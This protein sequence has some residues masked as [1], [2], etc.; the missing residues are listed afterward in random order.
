MEDV[1]D[2]IISGIQSDIER[3]EVV[4]ND[5]K[6]IEKLLLLIN[7]IC[8][9]YL[10]RYGDEEE[11]EFF[12]NI[13]YKKVDEIARARDVDTLQ[14]YYDMLMDNNILAQRAEDIEKRYID[15]KISV[16]KWKI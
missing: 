16:E 15:E 11:E 7:I 9:D 3:G 13:F 8:K 14:T 10:S 4:L 5:D 12:D 6:R 2:S 1:S